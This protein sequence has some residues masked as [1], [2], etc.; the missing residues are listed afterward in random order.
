MDTNNVAQYT[1][2]AV[3]ANH[4]SKPQVIDRHSGA[5]HDDNGRHLWKQ[6][7]DIASA[8]TLT[9]PDGT[10]SGASNFFDITG[11]TTITGINA[12][13][14][15][16]LYIFKFDSALTLQH[17]T[18]SFEMPRGVDLSVAAGDIVVLHEYS[19]GNFRVVGGSNIT[20]TFL[21]LTDSPSSY[22][23]QA[24]KLAAVN[25]GET[26]IEFISSGGLLKS[27]QVFPSSGTWTKPAGIT[28]VR[29]QVIGGGGGGAGSA[30][31]ADNGGGGGGGGYAEEFI[32]VSGTASETVTIGAG[33]AA[34][35]GGGGNGGNGGTASFGAFVSASGGAGGTNGG[36]GGGGGG[37]AGGHINLTGGSGE[38]GVRPDDGG[39]G[40]GSF[41]GPG[42]QSPANNAGGNIAAAGGGG[43]SGADGGASNAGGAGKAGVIIVWEYS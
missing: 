18:T 4:T 33:G 29:V 32:D 21:S 23:G 34:G 20:G 1:E 9:I 28:G 8:T 6:G 5:Y 16:A 10:A 13:S 17:T 30:G 43:G 31:T 25:S 24:N 14:T 38:S 11:T 27:V 12:K 7:T 41:F 22:S 19:S 15:G 26:A 39:A 42:G 36:A 40:G 37:G 3:G 35:S 2:E